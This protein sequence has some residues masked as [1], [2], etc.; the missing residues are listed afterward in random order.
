MVD[1]LPGLELSRRFYWEAVRPILDR[2]YPALA[3]TAA[4][5]GPGSEVLG[6]DDA[7]STDHHWGPRCQL[8]LAEHA[9]SAF[10]EALYGVLAHELPHRFGGYST[11][12]TPPNPDDSGTQLLVNVE[13]GPVNHRVEIGTIRAFFQS[14]LN[15]DLA[16]SLEPADWL[17]FPEQKLRTVVE[18]AVFHDD[19]GLE[20]IRSRLAYYP[21]D[22]W[23]YL[24]ASAW[25]RIGQEEHLMGRAGLVGDE[26]GSALMG[27]RLVRDVMRLCFLMERQYA[28]YPKWFGT[29][30]RQLACAA[31]LSPLLWAAQTASTWPQREAA[32]GRAYSRLAVMHNALGLTAPLETAVSPFHGRPF[33]V[34]HAERFAAALAARIAEPSIRRFAERGLIGGVDLFCDNTDLLSD[35]TWRPALRVLFS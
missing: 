26:L 35:A 34:I 33:Q 8:Y 21:H 14:Y 30:F 6:F 9:T 22:V 16:G 12:F 1:W 4:L 13:S 28:P 11:H 2:H 15:F 31:D 23:L 19:L 25:A 3:H 29:A 32:L 7:M 27:S 10:G 24:L 5:I 20:T 17:T 18:G